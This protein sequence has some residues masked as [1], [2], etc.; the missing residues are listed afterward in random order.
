VEGQHLGS[1]L[2]HALERQLATP[3]RRGR[4]RQALAGVDQGAVEGVVE[5]VRRRIQLPRPGPAVWLAGAPRFP[6]PGCR[7][8]RRAVP[9]APAGRPDLAPP[10]S[11]G[12]PSGPAA[13]A[14]ATPLWPRRAAAPSRG[15][16]PR[17]PT[18]PPPIRAPSPT[19]CRRGTRRQTAL[20]GCARAY[21]GDAPKLCLRCHAPGRGRVAGALYLFAIEHTFGRGRNGGANPPPAALPVSRD[22]VPCFGPEAC[23]GQCMWRSR[24]A[25]LVTCH[26]PR[27]P[28]DAGPPPGSPPSCAGRRRTTPRARRAEPGR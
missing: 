12:P 10:A 11:R 16:D 4:D 5:Q 17:A 7:P 28:A 24:R 8:G 18:G 3:G 14:G 20:G 2:L 15:R 21:R 25:G 23:T 6:S 26:R 13:R 1:R 22:H 9:A 19:P 27:S